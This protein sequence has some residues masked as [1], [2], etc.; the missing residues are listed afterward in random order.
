VGVWFAVLLPVDAILLRCMCKPGRCCCT[1][2][3]CS[4]LS[5]CLLRRAVAP[6]FNR[7][8]VASRAH[9]AAAKR[10]ASGQSARDLQGLGVCG[11]DVRFPRV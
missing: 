7:L 10:A 4:W 11:C 3:R 1:A 5:S 8:K 9:G 6:T 2:R